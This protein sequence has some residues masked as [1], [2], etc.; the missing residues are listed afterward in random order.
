M[1][2]LGV[3]VIAEDTGKKY[4]RTVILDTLMGIFL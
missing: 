2:K 4:G 3:S 1:R